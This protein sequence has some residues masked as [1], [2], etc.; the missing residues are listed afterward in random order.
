MQFDS[1]ARAKKGG[2]N[3]CIAI[4]ICESGFSASKIET[5]E[6]PKNK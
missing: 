1:R 5:P 3:C 2:M 4:L 6:A